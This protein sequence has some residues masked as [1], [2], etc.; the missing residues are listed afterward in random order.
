[1]SG[2]NVKNIKMHDWPTHDDEAVMNGAPGSR[3][4]ST[5]G[6]ARCCGSGADGV[7]ASHGATARP[8]MLFDLLDVVMF[9]DGVEDG[10]DAVARFGSGECTGGSGYDSTCDGSA[11]GGDEFR[12]ELVVLLR[13]PGFDLGFGFSVAGLRGCC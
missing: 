9:L 13:V 3:H 2:K 5:E 11:C 4:P 6:V 7:G 10:T 8:A 12:L 1:M